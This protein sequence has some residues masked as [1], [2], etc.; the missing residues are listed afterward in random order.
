MTNFSSWFAECYANAKSVSVAVAGVWS[1]N[2]SIECIEGNGYL[3]TFSCIGFV[4]YSLFH[5]LFLCV[6]HSNAL[7]LIMHP[8]FCIQVDILLVSISGQLVSF[9]CRNRIYGF[10]LITSLH[11]CKNSFRADHRIV[12]STKMTW[13]KKMKCGQNIQQNIQQNI[14]QNIHKRVRYILV[15]RMKS[16]DM[17]KLQFQTK[18]V[19]FMWEVTPFFWPCTFYIYFIFIYFL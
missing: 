6:F 11:A 19:V 18:N 15:T 2:N 1:T 9:K 3:P 7:D 8:H 10:H 14:P 5:S 17:N 16:R 4:R 12:I 13:P